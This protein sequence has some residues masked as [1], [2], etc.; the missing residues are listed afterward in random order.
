M[1]EQPEE[2]PAPQSCCKLPTRGEIRQSLKRIRGLKHSCSRCVHFTDD[3]DDVY[4][5]F[6]ICWCSTAEITIRW[7]PYRFACQYWHDG[8][9]VRRF[10]EVENEFAEWMYIKPPKRRR[11]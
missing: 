5:Q 3:S 4:G 11:R 10:Q 7:T 2:L 9:A 8:A 1:T 6:P